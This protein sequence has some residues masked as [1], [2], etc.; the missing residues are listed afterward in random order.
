MVKQPLWFSISMILLVLLVL[1][2]VERIIFLSMAQHTTG[3]VTNLTRYNDRCGG[4]K[5]RYS[6]TKFK[7]VVQYKG[8]KDGKTYTLNIEAGSSRGYDVPISFAKYHIDGY[9]PIVYSTNK[10]SKA[11][12]DTFTGVWGLCILLLMCQISTFV[13]ACRE[14]SP[15]G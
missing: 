12:E 2:V 7:A 6:C 8:L 14:D 5:S 4:R 1:K 10:P 9:A 13:V 3:T 11:Y 15:D